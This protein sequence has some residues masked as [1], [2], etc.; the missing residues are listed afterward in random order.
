MSCLFCSY[1]KDKQVIVEND[2]AYAIFDGYPVSDGHA[3]IISKAHKE[4]FFDLSS[5]EIQAFF[6]LAI[7]MKNIINEKFHPSSFNVGFNCG[8]DAGQTVMHCHMHIIPRYSGDSLNPR[9]GVRNI[10]EKPKTH[11]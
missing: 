6:E 7:I 11:Y 8:K 2:L 9:G 5:D 3:L 1:P 10:I 4:T